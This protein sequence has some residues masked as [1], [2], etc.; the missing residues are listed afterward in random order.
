MPPALAMYWR[1][2][3]FDAALVGT[4]SFFAIIYHTFH[5]PKTLW[6]DRASTSSL[7]VRT[8][9][10]STIHPTAAVV[11]VS[12]LGYMYLIYGYGYR[13]KC[14][15]FDPDTEV[16]DRYDCTLHYGEMVLYHIAL[17]FL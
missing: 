8:C 5:T 3:Y 12:Y 6:L 9:Y 16:G 1:G 17:S 7:V 15:S 2:F 11:T 13:N 4:Q 10:L 14:F